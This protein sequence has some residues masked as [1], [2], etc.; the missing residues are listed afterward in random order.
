MKFGIQKKRL[1]YLL[2]F[3]FKKIFNFVNVKS[4][5]LGEIYD[6]AYNHSASARLKK[7]VDKLGKPIPWFT[8][9]AIAY[10]ERL[11]LNQKTVFEWG[12]GHSSLYFSDKCQSITSIEYKKDW[13]KYVNSLLE[14]NMTLHHVGYDD[15]AKIISEIDESYD[16][17][18]IDGEIDRRLECAKEAIKYIKPGGLIILDNS[19]WLPNTTRFLRDK[20][21]QQIDFSGPGPIN[22]YFWSTSLYFS[23]ETKLKVLDDLSPGHIPG[24]LDNIRD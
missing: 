7:S 22:P 6:L 24:G 10:L 23:N 12:S 11:D 20:G 15:Y 3:F 13:Y 17:I 2:A 9:S 19:D 4:H 1:L 18:I 8:Y 16:I 21:Y 5:P 14:E